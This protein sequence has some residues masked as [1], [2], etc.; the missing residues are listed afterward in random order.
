ME[1]RGKWAVGFLSS[2]Q[3]TPGACGEFL[4]LAAFWL[5]GSQALYHVFIQWH[6]QQGYQQGKQPDNQTLNDPM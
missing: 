4:P 5:G 6:F 2:L 1:H 3:T